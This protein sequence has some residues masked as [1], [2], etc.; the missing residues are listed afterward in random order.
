MPIPIGLLSGF[1]GG[2]GAGAG[3]VGGFTLPTDILSAITGSNLDHQRFLT[4][5]ATAG[6]DITNPDFLSHLFGHNGNNVQRA[7]ALT[8]DLMSGNTQIIAEFAPWKTLAPYV[9]PNATGGGVGGTAPVYT[10]SGTMKFP[11]IGA[12]G[13]ELAIIIAI[14]VGSWFLKRK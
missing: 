5:W 8:A 7:G 2:G 9:N 14:A 13:I 12:V 11:V 1:L 4:I 6:Y 3:G 10:G